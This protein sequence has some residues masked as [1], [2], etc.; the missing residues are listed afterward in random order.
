ML[1]KGAPTQQTNYCIVSSSPLNVF[2]LGMCLIINSLSR[3]DWGHLV[4][5]GCTL[6]RD[7]SY[8]QW[9][10][11]CDDIQFAKLPPHTHTPQEKT[12]FKKSQPLNRGDPKGHGLAREQCIGTRRKGRAHRQHFGLRDIRLACCPSLPNPRGSK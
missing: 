5:L 6:N 3:F 4:F 8:Y 7:A 11:K 2:E 9:H 10:T 12:N 1:K